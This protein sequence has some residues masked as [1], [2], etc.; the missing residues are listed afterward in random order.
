MDEEQSELQPLVQ[1][2]ARAPLG[3][4]GK[5]FVARFRST[6]S[7]GTDVPQLESRGEMYRDAEGR[8]RIEHRTSQREQITMIVDP[9][10]KDLVFLDDIERTALLIRGG[11]GDSSTGW[12]FANCVPIET[13]DHETIHGVRCRRVI[14]RDPIS[15]AESGETWLADALMLAVSDKSVVNGVV[16]EWRITDLEVKDPQPDLFSI[17]RTYRVTID[18]Q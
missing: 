8:M 11:S 3:V 1:P 12:A 13:E 15:K 14:L 10:S 18:E 2:R 6:S 4:K 5:P 7:A 17:P 9:V 16:R